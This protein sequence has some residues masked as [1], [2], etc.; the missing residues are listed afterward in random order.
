MSP[1]RVPAYL[2]REF[3]SI[4]KSVLSRAKP[5]RTQCP[6]RKAHDLSEELFLVLC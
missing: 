3:L 4:K 1:G 6:Q 2:K 5:D